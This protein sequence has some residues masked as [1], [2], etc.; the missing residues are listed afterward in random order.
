MTNYVDGA[1][2]LATLR[3]YTGLTPAM[4][5]QSVW[6]AMSTHGAH[7]YLV[8]PDAE[9]ARRATAGMHPG[10]LL[11]P[12]GMPV[13]F[14]ASSAN[15]FGD[16]CISSG[17]GNVV[18]VWGTGVHEVSVTQRAKETGRTYL[19]WTDHFMTDNAIIP[20][21]GRNITFR[22][23]KDI[24]AAVGVPTAHQDGI[25]GP[26]TTWY[27]FHY[28]DVHKL[29]KDGIYGPLTDG[30]LFP[31][32]DLPGVVA[33]AVDFSFDRPGAAALIAAARPNVFRYVGAYDGDPRAISKT[34]LASYLA[35]GISVTLNYEGTGK[36]ASSFENGVADATY[37]QRML[38]GLGCPGA[39][40]YYSIDQQYAADPIAY[41]KGVESVQGHDSTGVYG[42][43]DTLTTLYNAGLCSKYWLTYAWL[44][45]RAIPTWVHAL[46]YLNDQRINGCAVDLDYTLQPDWGQIRAS[47]P[48]PASNPTPVHVPAA[49]KLVTDGILGPKTIT[50]WQQILHTP[51]DGVIS[52]PSEL[53]RAVQRKL[54]AAKC[55]DWQGKALVVDGLGIAQD[56]VKYRTTWALQ[57]YL[58]SPRDGSISTP[59]STVVAKL[60]ARLNEGRF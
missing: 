58:G 53:V 57:E 60:Q 29:E 5:L 1:A 48:A 45:G 17:N 34:E 55:R 8:Y 47:G 49:P 37:T 27:V 28:Q 2:A 24:Q 33:Q 31:N 12:I 13:W 11:P 26:E 59:H 32:E 9:S 35:A 6:N 25:Y 46:Q 21:V 50:R 54:N 56:G 44:N 52:H 30:S 18:G 43:L 36:D 14:G 20:G 51:V 15:D 10:D 41:F 39:T 3:T 16:V 19:G 42:S 23:T 22:P 4:C 40:V 7:S 38:A